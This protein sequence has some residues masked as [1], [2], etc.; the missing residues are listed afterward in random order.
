MIDEPFC[1][2]PALSGHPVLKE[3]CTLKSS[4]FYLK[5]HLK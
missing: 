5:E 1:I 4:L 3:N 2:G